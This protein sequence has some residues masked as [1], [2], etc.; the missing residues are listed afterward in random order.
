DGMETFLRRRILEPI[1]VSPDTELR[2]DDAGT[3]I[4]S[5]YAFMTLRDWCRF[6]LFALRD[7]VWEGERI[8]PEGWI[9]EGRRPRSADEGGKWHGAHWWT[10]R[11]DDGALGAHGFE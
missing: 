6:G 7:G 3:F 10:W 4:G 11:R 9:D 8:L 2:F 1:G 5:S